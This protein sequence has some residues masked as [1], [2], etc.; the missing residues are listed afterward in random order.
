MNKTRSSSLFHPLIQRWRQWWRMQTPSRQDRYAF[1]APL[2]A[3]VLF[4]AAIT[5]AFW[6]LKYEELEREQEVVRR[7]VEYAQQRLRLRLL[8]KQEQVMRIARDIANHETNPVGFLRDAQSLLNQT[9]E[10]TSLTW[11]D[12][13]HRVRAN[14]ASATA[15]PS[16]SSTAEPAPTA[17]T[18]RAERPNSRSLQRPSSG[19]ISASNRRAASCRSSTGSTCSRPPVAAPP[20]R[21]ATSP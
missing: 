6:Y 5:S 16:A 7:D 11:L 13:N 3:V 19:S 8:D 15:S 21:W 1:I 14:Y 18:A 12:A 9:P 20:C 10:L 2:A 17:S 4:M